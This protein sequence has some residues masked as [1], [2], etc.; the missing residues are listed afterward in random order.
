MKRKISKKLNIFSAIC[1]QITLNIGV[2][3]FTS[4]KV[5][6][7]ATNNLLQENNLVDPQQ[8]SMSNIG[9]F[10]LIYDSNT[11][12]QDLQYIFQKTGLFSLVVKDLNQL[13]L[14]LPVDIPIIFRDCGQA[15][16]WFN[17]SNHNIV[18]CYEL[19]GDIFNSLSSVYS[20]DEELIT[21]SITTL[22]FILYHEVGHALTDTLDLA[23]TGKEEDAVDDFAAILLLQE[24]NDQLDAI[25]YNASLYFKSHSDSTYWDEHS[26][27]KQRFVNIVC[28]LYGRDPQKYAAI[29]HKFNLGTRIKRCPG[30]YQ[31]KLSSWQRLLAPHSI[32]DLPTNRKPGS[33]DEIT[34]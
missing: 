17:P 25:V 12:Y 18:M 30:E 28:L 4:R 19:F 11:K 3:L 7:L 13:N 2:A 9:K 23:V 8:V 21:N 1:L 20:T 10:K 5:E 22:T 24:N 33:R 31:Q 6:S 32:Y 14:N 26:F 29:P 27:G 15:N 16:A 34:W